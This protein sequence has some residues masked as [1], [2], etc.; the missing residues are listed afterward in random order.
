MSARSHGSRTLVSLLLSLLLLSGPLLSGCSLIGGGSNSPFSMEADEDAFSEADAAFAV[1]GD[2]IETVLASNPFYSTMQPLTI[3]A[4]IEFEQ[5]RRAVV[6]GIIAEADALAVAVGE[7]QPGMAK[8]RG[9]YASYLNECAEADES[10]RDFAITA[11][12][13][14]GTNVTQIIVATAVYESIEATEGMDALSSSLIEYSKVAAS[15][16]LGALALQDL[17]EVLGSAA[18]TLEVMKSVD[19]ANID[20]AGQQFD[21]DMATA[22]ALVEQ[23]S[24]IANHMTTIDYGLRQLATADYYFGLEAVGFMAEEIEKLDELIANAEANDNVTEAD[25]VFLADQIDIYRDWNDWLY[26]SLESLDTSGSIEVSDDAAHTTSPFALG[27]ESAYGSYAPQE[28]YSPGSAF[29][30]AGSVI[31][32]GL[33]TVGDGLKWTWGGIRDVFGK[34][35]TVV[36]V[37]VDGAGVI[38]QT[39]ASVPLGVSNRIIYGAP[40]S[41]IND[42]MVESMQSAIE[43]YD[44]N[45]SGAGTFQQGTDYLD[46]MENGAQDLGEGLGNTLGDN[47]V[48]KGAGWVL[49]TGAKVTVGLFTDLGKGIYLV[50]NKKSSD[51]D[52]A[53]GFVQ[54]GLSVVGGSKVVVKGSQI[55]GLLKGVGGNLKNAG[56]AIKVFLGELSEK[57]VMKGLKAETAKILEK[58]VARGFLNADEALRL[59]ANS[60]LMKTQQVVAAAMKETRGVWIQKIKDAIAKGGAAELVHVKAEIAKSLQGLF[61]KSGGK[62]LEKV[63]GAAKAGLGDTWT[64][65]F[66]NVFGGWVEGQVKELIQDALEGPPEPAELNGSWNGSYIILAYEVLGE[67]PEGCDLSQLDDT[68]GTSRPLNWTLKIGDSG[69]GTTTGASGGGSVSYDRESGGIV[70]SS[71]EDGT[72]ATYRGTVTRGQG[73][74]PTTPGPL[75]MAG[76]FVITTEFMRVTGSWS[77]TK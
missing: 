6:E 55:P 57:G 38:A 7:F 17:E 20:A 54:I 13:E 65:W 11:L 14:L 72:K 23:S 62:G 30:K 29:G 35:K 69:T 47:V 28:D 63:L 66:D 22:D 34:A 8:L 40:L 74:D 10:T 25:L 73:A 26:E 36:G 44:N 18:I 49:G 5:D 52:V 9:T 58:G 43:N 68:I 33:K 42:N 48:G 1:D 46:G 53:F 64:E 50:L 56:Q 19:N 77:M 70:V 60:K 4:A 61:K 67:V 12:A 32:S 21:S 75:T 71:T 76:D 27:V 2:T 24:A 41:D 39:L 45:I 51:G 59:V 37:G 31:G 3:P 15:I 16:N